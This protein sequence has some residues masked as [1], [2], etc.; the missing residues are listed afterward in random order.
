MTSA[1]ANAT[2]ILDACRD[3]ELFGRWYRSPTWDAWHSFLRA[4]FGQHESV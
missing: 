1:V 2:T 4:L 3:P